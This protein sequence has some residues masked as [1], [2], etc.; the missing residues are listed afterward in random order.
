MEHEQTLFSMLSRIESALNR[1]NSEELIIAQGGDGA[2]KV[3]KEVT[4]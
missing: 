1:L 2:E 4:I 3:A